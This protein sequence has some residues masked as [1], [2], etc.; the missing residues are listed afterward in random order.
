MTAR[1]EDRII[2][3]QFEGEVGEEFTV[4]LVLGEAVISEDFV[5]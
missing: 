4:Q 1:S 5:I 2:Q 3:C